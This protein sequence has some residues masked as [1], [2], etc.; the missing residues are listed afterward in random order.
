MG[1]TM[2]GN[3]PGEPQGLQERAKQLVYVYAKQ[4]LDKTDNVKFEPEDVYVVWSVKVLNNWK[5]LV[6]TILPDGMYYEVTHDGV[7]C[8]D[9]LD[10]YKKVANKAVPEGIDNY[11]GVLEFLG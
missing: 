10:A 7:A 8:Y 1:T 3:A 5:V 2:N 9:Y 6:S 4:H 11:E